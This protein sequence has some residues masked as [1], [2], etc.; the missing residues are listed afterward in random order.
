MA[1]AYSTGISTSPTNLLQTLVTWL[2]GQG[3]AQDASAGEG[4]GWRAHLHK[5]GLYVNFRAASNERIWPGVTG[6]HDRG[7]GGYGIGLY[8]GTGYSGA[9]AWHLQAGMPTRTDGS[10]L[11]CGINLPSGSVSGYYLF[12]DGLD[13]IT[14]VVQRSPGVFCY[15]GFGPTMVNLGLPE[16][17]PYFFGSSSAYMNVYG[18]SLL[19]DSHG[20]NVT[21]FC[22]MSHGDVEPA[23]QGAYLITGAPATGLVKVDATTW[24]NR[25]AANCDYPHPELGY[26]GRFLRCALNDNALNLGQ[27]DEGKFPGYRFLR[28]RVH[29]AA[30][31]GALILPVHCYVWIETGGRWAPAGYLP[32]VSWCDAVGHGYSAAAVYQVGGVNY[33]LFPGFAVLKAA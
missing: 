22:P 15:M 13:N 21:A 27:C 23:D 3:W 6:Y 33:S 24:V 17:F 26:T 12:D 10:T 29:Q 2:V 8:L 28:G 11:G 25:W 20:V 19:T 14:V 18:G 32:T 9:S 4:S 16:N 31:A 5:S 7:S 30:F 1:A